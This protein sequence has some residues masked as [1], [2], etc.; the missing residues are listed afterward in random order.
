MESVKNDGLVMVEGVYHVIHFKVVEIF[1][2][3]KGKMRSVDVV[4]KTNI[5]DCFDKK[6]TVGM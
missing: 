4:G 5:E 2:S 3:K 6:R 1:C